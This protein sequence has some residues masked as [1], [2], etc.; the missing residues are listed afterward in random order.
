MSLKSKLRARG[1]AEEDLDA[2]VKSI[3]EMAALSKRTVEEVMVDL[4]RVLKAET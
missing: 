1:I 4:D 3:E 2:A